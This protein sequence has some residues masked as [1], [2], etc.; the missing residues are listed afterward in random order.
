MKIPA[1]LYGTSAE[2]KT[3]S[4]KVWKQYLKDP[5]ALLE[6]FE[7]G[8][9]TETREHDGFIVLS[10]PDPYLRTAA[11]Y[12]CFEPVR[13]FSFVPGDALAAYEGVL[14]ETLGQQAIATVGIRMVLFDPSREEIVQ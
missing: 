12:Q 4:R 14:G 10:G 8:G 5:Q 3:R 7:A 9:M 1:L 2:V 13:V 6:L 11:H